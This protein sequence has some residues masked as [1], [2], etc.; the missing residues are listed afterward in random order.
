MAVR[1]L[2]ASVKTS[3]R[4]TGL[5]LLLDK[6]RDPYISAGLWTRDPI[7]NKQSDRIDVDENS[8]LFCVAAHS[9]GDQQSTHSHHI[10][11]AIAS[12]TIGWQ[13]SGFFTIVE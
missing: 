4:E 6:D 3:I 10:V 11:F 2:R 13:Y 1:S 12:V 5:L 8:V 9:V 7:K